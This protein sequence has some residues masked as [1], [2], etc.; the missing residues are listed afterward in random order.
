MPG[1]AVCRKGDAMSD[2]ERMPVSRNQ[3]R[4]GLVPSGMM[5]WGRFRFAVLLAVAFGGLAVFG[6]DDAAKK[7]GLRWIEVKPADVEGIGWRDGMEMPFDRV[8]KRFAQDLP[9]VW[10]NGFSS[11]GMFFEFE[12]DTANVSVR[13]ALAQGRYG[14]DNFN[15]TAFAGTDLYVFDEARGAWRWASA[16]RHFVKWGP[17]TE[18]ALL[19]GLPPGRRRFRLYLPL[20]NRLK[21]LWIGVDSG[22]QTALRPPRRDK[23]VVYYGTS[24]IHGAFTIRPGLALTSRLERML[25]KPIVNLGF[26]GGARLEPK[27]AEMLAEIDAAI[28]VCDPYHNLN[29]DLIRKNFE[30]FFDTLCA[31]RPDTPV[32]LVGAPPLLNVWLFPEK[33]KVDDE[34]T[35]LFEE[36]SK[37]VAARHPNFRYVPGG[38]FYGS[39]EVSMDGVHPNDEAFSNMAKTLAPLIRS[40]LKP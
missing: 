30:P 8:P 34:K 22:S 32:M 13:T 17:E 28:Y 23:P 25:D 3:T 16:T 11:T 6:A 12:S 31:R 20:R 1:R 33:R 40:A 24:I 27:A 39:E 5:R 37:R 15:N 19:N 4:N 36:L 7:D 2:A 21:A 18:Y 10:R 14:E 38:Q 26:S 29:P 9:S 35:R